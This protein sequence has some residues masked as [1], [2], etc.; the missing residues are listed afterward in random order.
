MKE[1]P[2][3]QVYQLI[4]LGPVVLLATARNGRNNVMTMSWHSQDSLS[5]TNLNR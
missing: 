3:S 4:E 2:L 5:R 1:L